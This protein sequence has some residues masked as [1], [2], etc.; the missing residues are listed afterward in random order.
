MPS[1]RRP[2]A[3]LYYER[4]GD[5][6][7]L[8]LIPGLASDSQ[9]W[10]PVRAALAARFSLVL[11]DA[12]GAGRTRADAVSVPLVVDDALA[13]LDHLGIGRAHVL[14]HSLG[15]LIAHALAAR[16]PARVERLVLAASGAI[17]PRLDALLADLAAAREAGLPLELWFRLLF[18]WLFRPG[19]LADP[20]AVAVAARL[21]A[22]YPYLQSDAAFRAQLAAARGA[23]RASG[24]GITAPTLVLCGADD[25]MIAPAASVASFRDVPQLAA[26]TLADAAH[27]LHWDQPEAFVRAVCAFLTAGTAPSR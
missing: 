20:A 24:A 7:P 23:N 6:P 1:L 26:V 11:L 27:S 8:L 16:A 18:Q 19:L 9:S 2:D 4:E 21:A 17:S 22:A 13:L 3:E 25:L 12:R 15:G 10:L 14:G 5:G